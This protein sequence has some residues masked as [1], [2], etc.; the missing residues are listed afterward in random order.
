MRY[1]GRD[2]RAGGAFGDEFVV[3]RALRLIGFAGIR[4]NRR[5]RRPRL[6]MHYA[7]CTMHCF[8][9]PISENP[10]HIKEEIDEIEIQRESA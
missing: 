10:K 5:R 4:Q 9:F 3:I 6:A 8:L 2:V 7:L 1:E